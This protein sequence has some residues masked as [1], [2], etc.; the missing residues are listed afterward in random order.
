MV[1]I[2]IM[3]GFCIYL[4]SKY[5]RILNMPQYVWII[6]E[7]AWLCL[8]V[9]KSVWMAFV[10][11]LPIVF[12]YLKEPYAVFLESKKLI[13]FYSGWKYLISFVLDQIFFK[14]RFQIAVTF[15]GRGG[16][17][18]WIL[19]NQLYAREIHLFIYFVAVVFSLFGTSKEL[20]RDSQRL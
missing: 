2:L 17:G 18:Q 20:I 5:V 1:L 10:L 8:S 16:R 3:S 11:Y 12:P 15:G 7:Y 6:P 13:F 9:P 19:P 4:G 14:V